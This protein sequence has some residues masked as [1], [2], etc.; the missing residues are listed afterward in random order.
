MSVIITSEML[1]YFQWSTNLSCPTNTSLGLNR[2]C[3]A[4]LGPNDKVSKTYARG[5][6]SKPYMTMLFI[7]LS[8]G[9]SISSDKLNAFYAWAYDG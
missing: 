6:L 1:L 7:T 3:T 4:F 2:S 8:D 9:P 5:I